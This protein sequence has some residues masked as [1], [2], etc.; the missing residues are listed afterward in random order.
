MPAP[1]TRTIDSVLVATEAIPSE[2]F[3]PH[4][5]QD[6]S[7]DLVRDRGN[8]G[9]R[10]FGWLEYAKFSPFVMMSDITIAPPLV[11]PDH[12]HFGHE[13]VMYVLDGKA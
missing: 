1:T 12:P 6:S 2:N 5:L 11:F 13:F 4:F 10:G 7:V 3:I 8:V 9:V